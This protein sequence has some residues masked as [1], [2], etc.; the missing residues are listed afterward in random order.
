MLYCDGTTEDGALGTYELASHLGVAPLIAAGVTSL[1]SGGLKKILG[2]GPDDKKWAERSGRVNSLASRAMA[3]DLAAITELEAIAKTRLLN[4]QGGKG[5]GK[6]YKP[7]I[8][9]AGAAAKAAR[10]RLAG[11]SQVPLPPPVSTL[12][13]DAGVTTRDE[14]F[15][16]PITPGQSLPEIL[17]GAIEQAGQAAGSGFKQGA[18]PQLPP[19]V[20]PAGLAGGAVL[21]ALLLSKKN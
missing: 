1:V 18:T 20:I 4:G 2:G 12:P 13:P 8:Q 19:W 17:R 14:G 16:V 5:W 6:V 3:G 7:I 21:L 11:V 9:A 10:A 15:P